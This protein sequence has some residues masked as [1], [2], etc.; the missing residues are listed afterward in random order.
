MYYTWDAWRECCWCCCCC[1]L[2]FV[3][4]ETAMAKHFLNYRDRESVWQRRW[5][6]GADAAARPPGKQ[7]Q[8][9][10][11]GWL[12]SASGW[13]GHPFKDICTDLTTRSACVCARVC[14]CVWWED[15]GKYWGL[16]SHLEKS[17]YFFC[18]CFIETATDDWAQSLALGNNEIW[19]YDSM[20]V[21]VKVCVCV[22]V[23]V[24][25]KVSVS[26]WVTIA[27]EGSAKEESCSNHAPLLLPLSKP[28]HMR[29]VSPPHSHLSEIF[30][31]FS[32]NNSFSFYA[33]ALDFQ[34]LTVLF[35]VPAIL[36][37]Y[38]VSQGMKSKTSSLRCRCSNTFISHIVQKSRSMFYRNRLGLISMW[39]LL[40][41]SCMMMMFL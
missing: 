30:F 17:L 23:C 3:V 20:Y 18:V 37:E 21:H 9:V 13:I 41:L 35:N 16:S 32:L 40:W 39:L 28:S 8:C 38:Q 19:L 31:T 24:R 25:V 2:Q 22:C 14:V 12:I 36:A 27:P 15:A 1:F 29:S 33:K 4:M 7:S 10:V 11:R 34:L 6:S 5:Q 26:R